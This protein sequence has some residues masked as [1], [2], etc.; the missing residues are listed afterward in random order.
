MHCVIHPTYY[1]EGISNILLEACS[2]G[3]PIITTDRSGCRE[4]VEDG[5]NGYM[6]H[7]R[8]E[9]ALIDAIKKFITLDYTTKQQMGLSGRRIVEENLAEKL[10]YR[11]IWKK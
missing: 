10:L 3:R 5:V 7:E 6:V 8:D 1:P 11:R 2:S 4:V 9:G